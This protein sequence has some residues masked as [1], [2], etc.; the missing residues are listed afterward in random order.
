M[1]WF[2]LPDWGNI[3]VRSHWGR[4]QAAPSNWLLPHCMCAGLF[5]EADA[6]GS[7]ALDRKE[8]RTVIRSVEL[9]LSTSYAHF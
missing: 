7:G 2:G 4:L 3:V 9:G 5:A 8:F 6:D 1:V